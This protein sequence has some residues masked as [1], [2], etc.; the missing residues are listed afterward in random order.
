MVEKY[1]YIS[2]DEVIN[3][4]IDENQKGQTD[5]FRIWQIAYRSMALLGLQIFFEIK[6]LK[7]PINP[8]QT[9]NLPTDF[10]NYVKV[11][12]LNGAGEIVNL[13]FN[14]LQSLPTNYQQ[15]QVKQ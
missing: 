6:S 8:N 7:L 10:N 13:H 14:N 9:V 11:G 12:V 1:G 5:F 2:L 3:S 4:Y 15:G